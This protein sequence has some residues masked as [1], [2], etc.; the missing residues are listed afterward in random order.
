ML[1]RLV[2]LV[3]QAL[4]VQVPRR[5]MLGHLMLAVQVTQVLPRLQTPLTLH[6]S[7]HSSRSQSQSVA[8]AR[9][10]KSPSLGDGS[11]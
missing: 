2:M 5:V 4:L 1:A 10:A 11:C 3:R 7:G 8:G 9:Q 6:R